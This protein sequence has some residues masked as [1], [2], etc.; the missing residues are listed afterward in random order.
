MAEISNNHLLDGAETPQIM[1][2]KLSTS[3]GFL[4]R[5]QGPINSIFV[6]RDFDQFLNP[7]DWNPT[8]VNKNWDISN[9]ES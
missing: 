1:V 9:L 5:F 4:A 6:G 2:E 7:K 3:T 8:K